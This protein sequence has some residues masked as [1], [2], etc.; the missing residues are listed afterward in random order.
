MLC[1]V[2]CHRCSLPRGRFFDTDL[3]FNQQLKLL[4]PSEVDIRCSHTIVFEL[5]RIASNRQLRDEVV[6]WSAIP[7]CNGNFKLID[8]HFRLPMLHG[9]VRQLLTQCAAQTDQQR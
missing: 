3:T 7:L 4:G 9:E 8:G 1:K 5:F 6:G 2:L